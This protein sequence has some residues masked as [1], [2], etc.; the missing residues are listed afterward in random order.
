MTL[1]QPSI[2]GTLGMTT[3]AHILR[4]IWQKC[5]IPRRKT[6]SPGAAIGLS[7]LRESTL[8]RTMCCFTRHYSTTMSLVVFGEWW[9]TL[10]EATKSYYKIIS[11]GC[12]KVVMIYASPTCAV[13]LFFAFDG[14]QSQNSIGWHNISIDT[15]IIKMR[16][17]SPVHNQIRTISLSPHLDNSMEMCASVAN[18]NTYL[19]IKDSTSDFHL[20][21]SWG[22]HIFLTQLNTG[23]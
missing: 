4:Y 2:C 15:K 9:T 22:Y 5:P 10:P 23:Q 1:S 20:D 8:L 12:K 16:A 21:V 6:L 17:L 13:T 19:F 14:D 3:P 11:C 7:Y 18:N